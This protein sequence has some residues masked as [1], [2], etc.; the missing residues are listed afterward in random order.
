M[1]DCINSL[2]GLRHFFYDR[3]QEYQ[4]DDH[5]FQASLLFSNDLKS[6]VLE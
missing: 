2:C 6:G 1:P 3:I 4:W 5:F